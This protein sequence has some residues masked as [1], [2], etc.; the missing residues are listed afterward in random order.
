MSTIKQKKV[1][2]MGFREVG[3][4]SL[5][6][7]FVEG[8]FP[9]CYDPTIENTFQKKVTVKRNDY[10][11]LLVDTAG[12]DEYTMF[13]SEYSVGMHGYVLVYSIDSL[14]SFEVCNI[15]H[16]KLL[17]LMGVQHNLP[18]ILV[19]NKSDLHN[20]RCVSIEEGK[21][22]AREMKAVFLETSAKENQNVTDIFT[23]AIT[24]M[25]KEDFGDN[26]HPS[27]GSSIKEN[28]VVS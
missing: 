28:C 10:D 2:L 12:Q 13:P 4:S 1:A 15:I 17:G 3:K 19:G 18:I 27:A 8:Q 11:L 24:E 21:K 7:Q 26:E 14:R 20:D 5:A 22:L 25:E 9:D 23:S 6:I 16:E